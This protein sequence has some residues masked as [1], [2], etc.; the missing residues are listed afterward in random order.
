MQP[1]ARISSREFE[2]SGREPYVAHLPGI[3]NDRSTMLGMPPRRHDDSAV[4]SSPVDRSV[5]YEGRRRRRVAVSTA[6]FRGRGAQR[7][8]G[9]EPVRRLAFPP[10]FI[11][12]CDG[13]LTGALNDAATRSTILVSPGAGRVFREVELGCL[14]ATASECPDPHA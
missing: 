6:R 7:R 9:F 10:S 2:Y 14:G 5:A 13:T 8:R 1:L 4:S 12:L 11:H 3:G